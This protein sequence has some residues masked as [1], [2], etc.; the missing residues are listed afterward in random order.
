MVDSREFAC[1]SCWLRLPRH[2]K[3]GVWSCW[4]NQMILVFGM[5]HRATEWFQENPLSLDTEH[6][7][8]DGR[9]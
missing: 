4:D 9:A 3:I 5:L 1:S 2:L 8:S 7:G 6:A